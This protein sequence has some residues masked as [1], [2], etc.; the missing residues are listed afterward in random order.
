MDKRAVMKRIFALTFICLL[1]IVLRTSAG[2]EPVEAKNIVQPIPPMCDWTGFYIGVHGGWLG[3]ENEWHRSNDPATDLET[4][5]FIN[6]GFGGLQVGYNRQ[7]GR[8]FVIGAEL[9]GSY[10]AFDETNTVPGT[11]DF[12]QFGTDTK[13]YGTK[14]DWSGTF[15]LRAGFTSLD[16]K[17]F[18]FVKGGGAVTHWNYDYVND[19]T[20]A[21]SL[22]QPEFDR[23]HEEE[24]R[25]SPL[26]G[27]GLEYAITCHWTAKVE[28]NRTF[29]G[30]EKV[31]GTLHEDPNPFSGP[32]S[33]ALNHAYNIDLTQDSVIFGLNYKF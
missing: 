25:I 18:M 8:W 15:A 7:F 28:W 5:Q 22:R 6:G 27:A 1:P 21:N 20:L 14:Q 24:T 17:L 12:F 29:L 16:N 33:D 19:E 31:S 10:N 2:P 13:H 32:E 23:W 3:G 26:V 11:T 9:T 4:Q 30:E